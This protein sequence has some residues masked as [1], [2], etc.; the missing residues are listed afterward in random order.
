[1]KLKKQTI[2][3]FKNMKKNLLTLKKITNDTIR[4]TV[5]TAT[6][7]GQTEFKSKK[8]KLIGEIKPLVCNPNIL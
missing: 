1:M 7:K 2:K 6:K 3:K 4:L 5:D 8:N